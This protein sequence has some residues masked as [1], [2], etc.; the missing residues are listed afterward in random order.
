RVT[1][2]LNATGLEWKFQDAIRGSALPGRPREYN[3]TRR[4]LLEGKEMLPGE[5][6]TF[7]SHRQAW[8]ACLESKQLMLIL[9]D[10][11]QF[12]GDLKSLLETAWQYRE[13]YDVLRLNGINRV[14]KFKV[15]RELG[16]RKLVRMLRDPLGL[17]AYIMTPAAAAVLLEKSN[18]FHDPVDELV[19]HFWVHRLRIVS[20][21]PFPFTTDGSPTTVPNRRENR[22]QWAW[23]QKLNAKWLKLGISLSKRIYLAKLKHS[24]RACQDGHGS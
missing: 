8:Q 1:A 19:G 7:M 20:L 2:H 5:I 13:E 3:H 16:E 21:Y 4:L 15:I 22:P 14:G 23:Y 12:Q 18:P 11:F 24:L 17:A 9:E 6:G 10:D